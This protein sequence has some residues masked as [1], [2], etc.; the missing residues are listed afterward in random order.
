MKFYRGYLKKNW[1][2]DCQKQKYYI[3][4]NVDIIRL[5]GYVRSNI[6]SE[7]ISLVVLYFPILKLHIMIR[8]FVSVLMKCCLKYSRSTPY[9]SSTLKMFWPIKR[10]QDPGFFWRTP[11]A[12]LDFSHLL[13]SLSLV[14]VEKKTQ[15]KKEKEHN[16]YIFKN[17]SAGHLGRK[18]YETYIYVYIHESTKKISGGCQFLRVDQQATIS[19][20]C[21]NVELSRCSRN[22]WRA[23]PWRDA[24]PGHV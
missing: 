22:L 1:H 15:K 11:S 2:V 3:D 20:L 21:G 14:C 5:M 12:W 24:S 10:P 17:I 7:W 8:S 19:F 13:K 6:Y 23:S 4:K 9:C 18:L 16:L